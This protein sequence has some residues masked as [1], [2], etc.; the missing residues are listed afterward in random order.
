[1]FEQVA[2]LRLRH[3]GDFRDLD[4]QLLTLQEQFLLAQHVL[5]RQD[6][7][8][9]AVFVQ[10]RTCFPSRAV[11]ILEEVFAEFCSSKGRAYLTAV[12]HMLVQGKYGERGVLWSRIRDVSRVRQHALRGA[13]ALSTDSVSCASARRGL[14]LGSQ[15]RRGSI[16]LLT[17]GRCTLLILNHNLLNLTVL[18]KVLESYHG[19][20]V[21]QLRRQA[22][23]VHGRLLNYAYLAQ[24]HALE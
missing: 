12:E 7:L 5:R 13:G 19:A 6:F 9:F 17:T 2:V 1:M 14:L 16:L 4:R 22:Y 3:V 21:G 24:L 10:V 11:G 15:R 23:N 20:L 18:S 8:L